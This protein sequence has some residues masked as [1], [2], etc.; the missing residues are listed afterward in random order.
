MGDNFTIAQN[1]FGGLL[2]RTQRPIQFVRAGNLV[3]PEAEHLLTS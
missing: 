1:E 2:R 3:P